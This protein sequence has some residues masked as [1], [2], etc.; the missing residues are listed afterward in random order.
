MIILSIQNNYPLLFKI[1]LLEGWVSMEKIQWSIK[2]NFQKLK[3]VCKMLTILYVH[4]LKQGITS[5]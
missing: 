2:A 5:I 1:D 3:K 4:N